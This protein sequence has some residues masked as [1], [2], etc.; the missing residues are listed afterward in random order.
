MIGRNQGEI[1]CKKFMLRQVWQRA[2]E[3]DF[4]L[5]K[6]GN[7][8]Q[9]VKL[10]S[11]RE[12]SMKYLLPISSL[13]FFSSDSSS[14][15]FF[16]SANNSV[17][18]SL[19]Y[20]IY[21]CSLFCSY[22]VYLSSLYKSGWVCSEYCSYILYEIMRIA[23]NYWCS[24]SEAC[25]ERL[26]LSM[27][28]IDLDW[29][30]LKRLVCSHSPHISSSYIFSFL[31]SSLVAYLTLLSLKLSI[32]WAYLTNELKLDWKYDFK[33]AIDPFPRVFILHFFI[34]SLYFLISNSIFCFNISIL[35]IMDS[36]P[37]FFRHFPLIAVNFTTNDSSSFALFLSSSW[38][39]FYWRVGET[40]LV[41]SIVSNLV[42]L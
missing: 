26:F 12:L 21:F 29:F 5:K 17:L 37:L 28:F 32:W 13:I 20:W 10:V 25:F 6:Y 3:D 40:F 31:I 24:C 19:A 34:D 27:G 9:V 1:F 16:Y 15:I 33:D 7:K 4:L 8:Y 30:E 42:T 41:L 2:E 39:S 35:P 38:Y 11:V 14:S 36:L 23:K 22:S 18:L